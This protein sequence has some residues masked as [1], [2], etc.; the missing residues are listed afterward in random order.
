[1]FGCRWKS[2]VPESSYSERF[3]FRRVIISKKSFISNIYYS[4][5]FYPKGS[6]FRNLALLELKSSEYWPLGIKLFRIVT[7]EILKVVMIITIS[8]KKSFEI[9][10][11]RNYDV[12]E[13][14]AVAKP[15]TLLS[16]SCNFG[17]DLPTDRLSSAISIVIFKYKMND[18]RGH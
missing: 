11:I 15:S 2:I 3:L 9:K 8:K 16:H 4:E 5:K 6:L 18:H 13:Y 1:M 14:R 7:S 10:I 12:S 17:G